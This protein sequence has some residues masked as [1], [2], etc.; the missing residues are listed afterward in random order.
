MNN[1]IKI[2]LEIEDFDCIIKGYFIKG[3]IENFWQNYIPDEF[4]VESV[5]CENNKIDVDYVKENYEKE[6]LEEVYD[7]I[8][9]A[10]N[11]MYN[12]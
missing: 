7:L 5:I 11:I 2:N 12:Y 6:C 3:Q 10:N 9:E 1:L 8:E 4:E